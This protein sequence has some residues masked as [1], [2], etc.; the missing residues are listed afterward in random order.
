MLT[1]L[2]SCSKQPTA[3]SPDLVLSKPTAEAN[4]NSS[5]AEEDQLINF[6][7]HNHT[8]KLR[9]HAAWAIHNSNHRTEE[10]SGFCIK[11]LSDYRSP[12]RQAYLHKVNPQRF[13]V[14]SPLTSGHAIEVTL[15]NCQNKE[16]PMPDLYDTHWE[17][18]MNAAKRNNLMVLRRAMES[19]FF[20]S[21][22]RQWWLYELKPELK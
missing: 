10:T 12:D 16:I 21:D 7:F 19:N 15:T 1:C 5:T 4:L 2:N 11:I 3:A 17:K 22:S 20:N 14:N 8:F 6:E 9:R 13:G 18:N